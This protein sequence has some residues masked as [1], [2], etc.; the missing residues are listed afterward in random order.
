MVVG[1]GGV[2]EPVAMQVGTVPRDREQDL[3]PAA[4]LDLEPAAY[5]FDVAGLPASRPEWEQRQLAWWYHEVTWQR[6]A[7]ERFHGCT[8]LLGE[9]ARD[10]GS[11]HVPRV[12]ETT[13]LNSR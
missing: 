12:S 11:V 3:E 4:P 8:R 2:S 1:D 6:E 5:R 9:A 7:L 13:W 10:V